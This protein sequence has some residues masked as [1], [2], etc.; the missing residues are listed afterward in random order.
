[1]QR[2]PRWRKTTEQR[3]SRVIIQAS[4]TGYG[5]G[6][7]AAPRATISDKP[8]PQLRGRED[9]TFCCYRNRH[10]PQKGGVPSLT[11]AAGARTIGAW[12]SFC[13]CGSLR[14]TVWCKEE[15]VLEMHLR[16]CVGALDAASFPRGRSGMS[17]DVTRA[18]SPSCPGALFPHKDHSISE[19]TSRRSYSGALLAYADY[20]LTAGGARAQHDHHHLTTL[21]QAPGSSTVPCR[22]RKSDAHNAGQ[23]EIRCA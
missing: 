9:A 22:L 10:S 21:P 5:L 7:G 17:G 8:R 2:H 15:V 14:E 1:M 11:G 6:D 4:R 19:S 23:E 20:P 3:T 13:C 16:G 12:S 18:L